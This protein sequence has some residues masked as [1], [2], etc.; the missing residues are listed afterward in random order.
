MIWKD[1]SIG[2]V[3]RRLCFIS[4]LGGG[5]EIVMYINGVCKYGEGGVS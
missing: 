4:E 5:E 1:G 3:G 2:Y